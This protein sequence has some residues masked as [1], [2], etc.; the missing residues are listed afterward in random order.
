M[1][2]ATHSELRCI[3]LEAW[4]AA[5]ELPTPVL[6]LDLGLPAVRKKSR[7]GFVALLQADCCMLLVAWQVKPGCE[8]YDESQAW[9]L[10]LD[11]Y[12]EWRQQQS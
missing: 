6:Q 3:D 7:C 1:H 4:V 2:N 5:K 8:N 11:N 9:P 12:V 10:L